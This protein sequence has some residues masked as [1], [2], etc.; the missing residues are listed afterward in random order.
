MATTTKKL[1]V[2]R[3]ADKTGLRRADVR[4]T[5][6][7]FLDEIVNDLARGNRLEFRDFGV[8]EIK[9]RAARVGQ[10][11]RTLERV[12]VPARKAVRFKPGRLMYAAF[13]RPAAKKIVK[14][15]IGST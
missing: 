4:E 6:Q 14:Q 2:D 9:S 11:P 7:Q 10:N 13:E 3:I 15:A 1:L 5:I 8:F 12:D